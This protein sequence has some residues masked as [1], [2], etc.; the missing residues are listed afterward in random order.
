M[1]KS[2]KQANDLN[3]FKSPLDK[4]NKVKLDLAISNKDQ[5]KVAEAILAKIDAAASILYGDNKDPRY[6]A[7]INKTVEVIIKSLPD[8][9]NDKQFK[10]DVL[11]EVFADV[12][13]N[14][15]VIEKNSFFKK[16]KKVL[17]KNNDRLDDIEKKVDKLNDNRN[18]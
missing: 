10:E 6:K 13:K 9:F 16:L 7:I 14:D 12:L 11:A 2:P 4:L 8:F 3:N 1:S 17:D 15:N 5:K 18:N